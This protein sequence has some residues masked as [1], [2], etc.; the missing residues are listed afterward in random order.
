MNIPSRVNPSKFSTGS[1]PKL[2]VAG[3]INERV[4]DRFSTVETQRVSDEG[5][6]ANFVT[7]RRGHL[8]SL[9]AFMNDDAPPTGNVQ[10]VTKRQRQVDS[11]NSYSYNRIYQQQQQQY[12]P[13]P[14]GGGRTEAAMMPAAGISTTSPAK[15]RGVQAP[16]GTDSSTVA[17]ANRRRSGIGVGPSP[18]AHIS[19]VVGGSGGRDFRSSP[20]PFGNNNSSSSGTPH[21]MAEQIVVAF[22]PLHSQAQH[23][24]LL[25]VV[26]R[27]HAEAQRSY[28]EKFI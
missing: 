24:E 20:S 23:G 16:Y 15:Q 26:Y 22:P 9:G 18:I 11:I 19:G 10:D 12:P 27:N 25:D 14:T 1:R 8:A 3:K 28:L 6:Q 2:E 13:A 7:Q 4:I 5:R 21:H 17:D